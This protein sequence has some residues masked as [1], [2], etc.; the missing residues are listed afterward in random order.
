MKRA[1]GSRRGNV[2]L[3]F[4]AQSAASYERGECYISVSAD[5]SLTKFTVYTIM[6]P[7]TQKAVGI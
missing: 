3:R 2:A 7:T 6:K 4:M 5:A 1:F